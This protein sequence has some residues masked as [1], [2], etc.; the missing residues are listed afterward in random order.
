MEQEM[1]GRIGLLSFLISLVTMPYVAFANHCEEKDMVCV[2][3]G[4]T[5]VIAGQNITRDCWKYRYNLDCKR[6]SKNDCYQ[7]DAN[8]CSFVS[9]ECIDSM[10]E[11][12]LQFC[13]N[14]KRHYACS[15]YL[16]YEEEKIELLKNG[17]P[18][19]SKDLMCKAMCL[20]GDCDAVKKAAVQ[21]DQDIGQAV[22]ILH[23]LK[24]T[25]KSAT[26][27]VLI[28][29]FKGENK[30]CDRKATS[31]INCCNLGGWG[32]GLGASCG[33]E[34]ENLAKSRKEKKCIEVG[35]YCAARFLKACTIRRTTFCCYDS[36]I[37]KIINQEA[38]KKLGL[39]NG[40]AKN[41]TCGGLSL[42]DLQRV[43]LS[44][45]DFSEFYKEVVVP[46]LKVP[47]LKATVDHNQ[48]NIDQIIQ[49]NLPKG[50]KGFNP[51][52]LAMGVQ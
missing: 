38:K 32:R 6:A 44:K 52:V 28:N 12:D 46:N 34:A 10:T 49:N 7:I 16:E 35:T 31:Y 13:A 20:D 43:D 51:E 14:F 19:D 41:P 24:E 40:T 23:A 45:A 50:S 3:P 2:E 47:D 1:L 27:Q 30:S 26:D 4:S 29:I 18:A 17:S 5:R 9:E 22:G 8:A 42:E 15:Q 39:T 21:D 36:V 25:K 37:A 48:H 33:P 11:G